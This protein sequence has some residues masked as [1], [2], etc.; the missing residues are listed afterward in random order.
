MSHP[1]K[2]E[3][4]FLSDGLGVLIPLVLFLAILSYLPEIDD[5]HVLNLSWEWLTL[6]NMPIHLGLRLDGLSMLFG[7]LITGIGT[8]IMYYSTEY[9]AGDRRKPSFYFYLLSFMA[10]MLGVV[11]ASNTI[12][13]FVFWELTTIT[14]FL[15][16][17][18][19]YDNRKS[20]WS[21]IQGLLVTGLGGF[22]LLAGIVLL[23]QIV[24]SYEF[25]DILAASETLKASPQYVPVVVLILLGCFTKSAQF[26]FHFWLPN[27]MVAPTPVSAFL[28]SATMVKAGVYLMARMNPMLGGTELWTWTLIIF[29]GITAI[30]SSWQSIRSDDGKQILAYSTLMALGT[31]TLFI[32]IGSKEALSTAAMFILI[33]ALYK[34]SLFMVIGAVDHATGTRRTSA[35]GGLFKDMPL[36]GFVAIL[37][38]LSMAGLPPF[39]GFVGKELM[40]ETTLHL[41]AGWS[42]AP[43]VVTG[44]IFLANAMMFAAA[45]LFVFGIFFGERKPTRKTTHEAPRTIWL[46]SLVLAVLGLGFG[47][48]VEYLGGHGLISHVV[49][50]IGGAPPEETVKLALW[51]GPGMVLYISLATFAAGIA[52]YFI[53]R[54]YLSG[55]H[56]EGYVPLFSSNVIYQQ[57]YDAIGRLAEIV[58]GFVQSGRLRYYLTMA[59]GF[60]VVIMAVTMAKFSPFSFPKKIDWPLP[61]E[62]ALIAM[63]CVSTLVV[64]VSTSR[65]LSIAALGVSGAVIG[66]IYLLFSAPD[67]AITQ[68]L[69]ETLSVIIV[70]LVILKL[71]SFKMPSHTGPAARVRDALIAVGMGGIVTALMLAI[72]SRPFDLRLSDYFAEWSYR[73]AHGHNVVNVIIVDFRGFDTLGEIIVVA[74][75]AIGIWAMLKMHIQT[76]KTDTSTS[77]RQDPP[78]MQ[79]TDQKGGPS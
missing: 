11:M 19:N 76:D 65:L 20:R 64:L 71:P 16:I 66:I 14:S 37:A 69:I 4:Y 39:V 13:L 49:S 32:G 35:L 55:T 46:G 27:A 60:F 78:H 23:G 12:T 15:L 50:V 67:L 18:F 29:G 43:Y 24:G 22:C 6:G 31:L 54:K 38:A 36:S 59:F 10:S 75:A 73:L 8:L 21:A 72:V 40:Y 7:L 42:F 62:W 51:H 33:H 41:H 48:F 2:P 56:Y 17:G 34:A 9:M 52:L 79:P 68:L 30:Y 77:T 28:H 57:I 61:Y 44:V 3:R 25:D 74:I 63:I 70:T 1:H 53:A 58:T 26:P 45:A 5:G 47:P